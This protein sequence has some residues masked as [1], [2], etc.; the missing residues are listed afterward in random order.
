[1]RRPAVLESPYLL[2]LASLPR[3]EDR[4][5]CWKEVCRSA[6]PLRVEIGVGNSPFLIEVSRLEPRFSY[7]GFEYSAKRVFKFLRKVHQAGLQ[8][9]FMLC[10][11]A[12]PLLGEIAKPGRVDH[13]FANFPDPWPK[14]RHGKKRLVTE[15]NV[16]LL[17]SLLRPGGG[18][19]LRTDDPKYAGQMLEIL[20]AC[21]DL[22]NQGGKGHFVPQPRYAFPTPYELKYRD[23]GRTIYYLEYRKVDAHE[24]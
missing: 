20:G 18:L 9:I 17:A 10:A 21:D 12:I 19:S 23:A 1:M 16:R 3:E 4:T 15:A 6:D 5:V 22:L 14:R 24:R 2:E 8:N 13:F 11:N 7:V